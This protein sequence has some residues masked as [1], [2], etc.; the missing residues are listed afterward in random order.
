MGS[1]LDHMGRVHSF[2]RSE[3]GEQNVW[4][5]QQSTTLACHYVESPLADCFIA[6]VLAPVLTPS[7]EEPRAVREVF[8]CCRLDTFQAPRGSDSYRSSV[9]AIVFRLRLQYKRAV[10]E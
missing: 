9:D 4:S 6:R 3:V 2:C 10:E 7:P 1:S 8:L 5:T